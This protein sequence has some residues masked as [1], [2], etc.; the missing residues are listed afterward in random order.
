MEHVY[1]SLKCSYFHFHL[2]INTTIS[3]S[4]GQTLQFFFFFFFCVPKLC[5]NSRDVM[6]LK[7]TMILL[8]CCFFLNSCCRVGHKSSNLSD[9]L[10][11]FS[12]R[13]IFFLFLKIFLFQFIFLFVLLELNEL[14]NLCCILFYKVYRDAYIFVGAAHEIALFFRDFLKN[15]NLYDST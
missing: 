4:F 1:R 13:Q 8:F 7:I 14:Q 9:I 3:F 11:T 5:S 6:F 15:Q 12:E 2:T 10:F